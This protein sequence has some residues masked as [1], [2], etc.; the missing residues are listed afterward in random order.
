MKTSSWNAAVRQNTNL[1]ISKSTLLE[2]K[3][4]ELWRKLWQIQPGAMIQLN[5]ENVGAYNKKTTLQESHI[6][7][8]I[9]QFN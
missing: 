1:L 8:T 3:L 7:V 2:V 5:L 4:L 6:F 9:L